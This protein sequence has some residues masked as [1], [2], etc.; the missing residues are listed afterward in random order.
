M[1]MFL[2]NPL[3][4]IH[5]SKVTPTTFALDICVGVWIGVG[6]TYVGQTCVEKVL[7][8]AVLLVIWTE[9]PMELQDHFF[10]DMLPLTIMFGLVSFDVMIF[11]ANHA[12]PI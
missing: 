4:P 11:L 5:A 2:I 12:C 6:Q 1:V 3:D 10:Q 7:L 9:F 8:F